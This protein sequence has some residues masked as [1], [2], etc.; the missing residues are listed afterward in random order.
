VNY[1]DDFR[2]KTNR[3]LDRVNARRRRRQE[4]ADKI[5]NAMRRGASLHRFN[6]GHRTIWSLSTGEFVTHEA[7]TDALKDPRVAGVGDCLFGSGELSQTFRFV[8]D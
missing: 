3:K 1:S 6:R 4:E 8:E 2:R 7:A 5:I